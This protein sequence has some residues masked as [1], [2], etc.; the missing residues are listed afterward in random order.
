MI[1]VYVK[2]MFNVKVLMKVKAKLEIIVNLIGYRGGGDF[3]PPLGKCIF[4]YFLL[5][6][7]G[8]LVFTF[9]N[10]YPQGF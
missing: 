5:R 2:A 3:T 4:L 8:I 7:P 1:N 9:S 10:R 6:L